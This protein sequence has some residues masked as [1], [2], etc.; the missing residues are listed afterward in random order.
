LVAVTLMVTGPVL[1][2]SVP[3]KLS[4]AALNLSQFGSAPPPASVAE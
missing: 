2:A 1:A 3:L 4:V